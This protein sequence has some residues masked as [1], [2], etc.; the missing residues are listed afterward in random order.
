MIVGLQNFIHKL[1]EGSGV[2]VVKGLAGLLAF[3]MLAI[4]YNQ[5]HFQN[6]ST[7]EA[8]DN[9]QLARNLAE[10]KGYQTSFIRP[11]SLYLLQAKQGGALPLQGVQPDL[12]NP[13]AYPYLLAQWMRVSPFH[14]EIS[15]PQKFSR[16]EPEV[17][18][19][20][21]NQALFLL[22][23]WLLFRLAKRLFDDSV[24]WFAVV[25]L[26][27]SELLWKFS[28][29][30]LA[31]PLLMLLMVLV[32][33]CLTTAERGAREGQWPWWKLV[34]LALVTGLLVGAMG[35]TR[36]AFAWL[37]LPT[38]LFFVIA[39]AERKILLC[40]TALLGFTVVMAPWLQR[41]YQLTGR[42]FGTA[43][44]S[45]Y[46]DTARFPGNRLER[47]LNPVDTST[48]NDFR[49]YSLE[50]H[51]DKFLGNFGKVLQNDLPKL[52]GSWLSAFFLAGLLLPF[53]NPALSRLRWFVALSILLLA[54][55]QALTRT[56]LSTASPDLNSENL[57]VVF[58]PLVF[59]Y[60]AGLYYIL[61]EQVQVDFPPHRNII[62]GFA[63]L[64]LCLPLVLT[65]LAGRTVSTIAAPYYPQI[66]QS[67]ANW[68]KPDELMM[69][70]MPWAVAWYGR[71]DCLWLTTDINNDYQTVNR[72]RPIKALYLTGLTMDQKMI[73]E[74]LHGPDH[75][76][77]QFVLESVIKQEL[78]DGF[79]LRKAYTDLFPEQLF[80]TDRERWR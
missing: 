58:A 5:A 10:G 27:G 77:G 3:V 45:V 38:A 50:E 16:Y 78:P 18:I 74:L 46:E 2:K 31:T 69:S 30:G 32:A 33:G 52:G 47:A 20:W 48:P 7:A 8:M 23:L 64:V 62:T 11:F 60:G 41:N 71:R 1:E 25:V 56:T 14:Y 67:T 9:A 6:F 49:K 59:L 53:Q 24:A 79:P 66:V 68:M 54:V 72:E 73:S 26:G 37:M 76:W 51:W 36:Y 19:A 34:P 44:F 35:L 21:L 65:L 61:L 70:D 22:T 15:D 13:P 43:A 42:V 29:A 17:R 80:L 63:C 55:V 28:I 4:V 40:L 39:F 75:V 12:S 57:L